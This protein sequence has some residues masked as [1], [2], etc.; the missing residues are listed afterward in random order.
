MAKIKKV[1]K[2]E[3]SPDYVF[4]CP[5]CN[6]HQGV[7]T[8]KPNRLGA[9]WSFNGDFEKPTI[10]PS[11]NLYSEGVGYRCHSIITDG[12]ISFCSDSTHALSGQTVEL[13]DV[14]DF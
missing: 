4:F 9:I 8:S 2:K 10:K 5:G 1:E 7:W 11:L 6:S 3:D 14:D 13:P 12:K